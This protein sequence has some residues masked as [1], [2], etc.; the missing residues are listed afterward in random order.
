MIHEPFRKRD[1]RRVINRELDSQIVEIDE[2]LKTG[3]DELMR[4][5][6]SADPAFFEHYQQSRMIVNVRSRRKQ[7]IDIPALDQDLTPQ[8]EEGGKEEDDFPDTG[9]Y[10]EADE[11][12]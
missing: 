8:S 12:E 11:Q 2:L 9:F 3:L 1:E 6:R 10:E 5:Y 4:A 7:D